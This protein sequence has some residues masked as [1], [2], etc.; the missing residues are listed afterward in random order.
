[1]RKKEHRKRLEKQVA[2]DIAEDGLMIAVWI[3]HD[4]LIEDD[5]NIVGR[6]R[7][8]RQC[9]PFRKSSTINVR[10]NALEITFEIYG[11]VFL[12]IS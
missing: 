1:M 8:L 10:L 2:R 4:G 9:N 3:R 7:S 12:Y 6:T 11:C 5:C